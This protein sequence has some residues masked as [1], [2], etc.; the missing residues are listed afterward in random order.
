MGLRQVVLGS[1]ILPPHCAHH[2]GFDMEMGGSGSLT[3]QRSQPPGMALWA[4]CLGR[5]DAMAGPWS[6]PDVTLKVQDAP[7]LLPILFS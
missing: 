6:V 4:L 7:V 3:E 2:S 1:I 5:P